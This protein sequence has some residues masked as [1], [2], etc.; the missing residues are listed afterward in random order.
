MTI[1]RV[2]RCLKCDELIIT[3]SDDKVVKCCDEDMIEQVPN[4]NDGAKETHVPLIRRIGNLVTVRVGATPHPMIDV[5]HLKFI[6]L[7]TNKGIY[8]KELELEK[9]PLADFLIL[10]EE[11]IVCAY[12]YCN[13]HELWMSNEV[14]KE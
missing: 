2:L 5:H 6:I 9:E 4:S 1:M 13:N 8:Y 3:L 10:N 7:V 14:T 12:A 11:E